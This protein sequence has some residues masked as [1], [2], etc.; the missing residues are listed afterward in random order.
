MAGSESSGGLGSY[1]PSLQG[2]QQAIVGSSDTDGD[3][4]QNG[5]ILHKVTEAVYGM[6]GY[7]TST[8]QTTSNDPTAATAASTETKEPTEQSAG[9]AA[10]ADR[11]D[12]DKL[13]KSLANHQPHPLEGVTRA[14]D[15]QSLEATAK[16]TDKS[17]K[18]QE[19]ELAKDNR[20]VKNTLDDPNSKEAK[21]FAT[22]GTGQQGQETATDDQA[23]PPQADP[24]APGSEPAKAPKDVQ[25][26]A[27]PK[28]SILSKLKSKLLARWSK[29]KQMINSGTSQMAQLAHFKLPAIENEPNQ[30][31]E[32]GSSS[33]AGLLAAL[34][35]MRA[36]A[37][38]E[39][40]CIINGKEVKT[41]KKQS[42][43]I[44]ADH[45]S[46]LCTYHEATPSDVD[47]A[48]KGALAA[49]VK[50]ES[51]AWADRAAI[52]LKAADLVGG[53]YRYKI[54]AA[55]MLGQGK[56]AWQAEIDAAAELVDFLRFSAKYTEELYAQQPPKNAPGVWNRS[57][58]RALDGFVLA[59]SPFNFTAIGGNLVGAPAIVGNVVLW[60]PS[61][62]A[63]YSNYILY[64]ILEEA[65]LPA[66][67]IQFIPGP[68]E[69]IVAQSFKH[70]LFAGLHFTGS[71]AVFKKLWK[72]IASNIEIYKSY[73]RIV[74]ETGGKNFHLV[75]KSADV[76]SSVLQ[77]I[78]GAFE[79]QGQKCSALSRLYVPQSLW[80][81]KGGFKEQLIDQVK[82][83]TLGQPEE[84][85]H[86]MGPVIARHSYDKITSYIKKAKAAGGE[87]IVGGQA[88][89]S[90]GFFVHP[91]V[92]ETKDPKSVTMVEEIF[93]PVITAYAYPD[94]K[95]EET[96]ELVKETTDYALTGAV[97]AQD[98]E[99]VAY[100]A[101]KLRNAAGNF[102]IND[103]CTGAVVGQQPFGGSRGSGTN[104]KAG[105]INL[106]YRFVNARSIKETFVLPEQYLYP[107]NM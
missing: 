62:M 1:L 101:D 99:A 76:K 26:D 50:W 89:D 19:A 80:E 49:K 68:A 86:F 105:S 17:R 70:P 6:A 46:S 69:A 63:V 94:D 102:Y 57:E 83:I 88:D 14:P 20:Q 35:Q 7:D 29:L 47:S 65:G 64:Q 52:F 58:Y 90:K 103:K 34:A 21:A 5:G 4:A 95:F 106:L 33:R 23:P 85:E 78:R 77:A 38:F 39:I 31:Y 15:K 97:F 24:P 73:P 82:L 104:D 81:G 3:A 91:T 48:I 30:H 25:K 72:D 8:E 74:G 54:M 92:I 96:I 9:T 66:G 42:Q 41:G 67:V 28:Q 60:K 12:D 84:F 2:I 71:T 43:L 36:A 11:S 107:S 44:P 87:V 16:Q 45:A 61:P 27:S 18:E 13:D 53:K 32:A 100:M 56:N 79:Y 37:P 22:A 98:R 10:E 59:V 75:H 51:M 40:P 93:G 55:T